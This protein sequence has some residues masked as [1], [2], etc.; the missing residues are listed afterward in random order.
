MHQE[1]VDLANA[2]TKT[3]TTT[4]VPPN[5]QQQ[6]LTNKAT[7]TTTTT[8][9]S[10][11][12][13]DFDRWNGHEDDL[14]STLSS[15]ATGTTS[16]TIA[17]PNGGAGVITNRNNSPFT[18]IQS[19]NS[20]PQRTLVPDQQ[21]NIVVSSSAHV[22]VDQVITSNMPIFTTS[23]VAAGTSPTTQYIQMPSRASSASN[24]LVQHPGKVESYL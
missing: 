17:A 12:N 1:R 23:S 4:P 7:P 9:P 16:T 14:E 5:Q 6:Q 24:I 11:D 18:V 10:I 3:T 8:S 15:N 2:A 22:G 20:A 13:I 21:T 19:I